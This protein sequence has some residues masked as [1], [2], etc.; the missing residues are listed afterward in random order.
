MKHWAT[1]KPKTIEFRIFRGNIAKQGILRNLEFVDA[2]C[3]FVGTV[4]M[5]R[6]TDTVNRLSYTNFVEYMNTS[7]NKGTLSLPILMASSQGL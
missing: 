3:N 2:L 6:D 4:G 5:D 7:E 1:H